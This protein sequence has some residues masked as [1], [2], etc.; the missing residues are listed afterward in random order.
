MKR[1]GAFVNNTTLTAHSDDAG[2]RLDRILRKALPELPLSALH[3]LLRKGHVLVNGRA[4]GGEDRI[5][6]G[7]VIEIAMKTEAA[8]T[9]SRDRTENSPSSLDIL[10]E[11]AGLLILNK[12]VGLAVH[13]EDDPQKQDSL[14]K[15]VHAYLAGTLPPSLSFKPGPLHRLDKGTSGI[16]VFSLNLEAAQWFSALLKQGMIRKR[17][18]AVLEGE[19]P[20]SE[21]WEDM[22]Y[23]D[24]EARTTFVSAGPSDCRRT[25]EQLYRR[26][27][28]RITPLAGTTRH[29]RSFTYARLEIETGRTH[30]IRAQ[31]AHHGHPLVGDRK[32]G[33][34][35]LSPHNGFFLHA[36]EL[37]LPGTDCV[38]ADSTEETR[39]LIPPEIPRLVRAPLPDAFAQTV[40]E[41]FGILS[42]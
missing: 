35:L 26:A 41:L 20:Q 27:C 12:P 8:L 3:K 30:Q 11:G 40:K 13:G 37:E 28:T 39:R 17:Y 29:G 36:A 32:Y 34:S 4:A 24:R 10:W 25:G 15:R 23:R 1:N 31:A 16:V 38:N 21:L 18:L 42:V 7:A 9:P 5:P 14:E 22:L 2:R 33:G 19:L 6:A